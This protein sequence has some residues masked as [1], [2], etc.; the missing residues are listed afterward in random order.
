MRT[1]LITVAHGRHAHLRR[2]HLMVA[3]SEVAV[4]DYIVVAIDDAILVAMWEDH[5]G[6]TLLRQGPGRH[7]LP[8]AA[9]RNAGAAAALERGAE[10]LVF[11]DV[12]C[13]PDPGLVGH[14]ARAAVEHPESLLCGP[15]AYL[16]QTASGAVMTS[17][18]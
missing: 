6:V 4:D 3:R 9:A 16:P 14:Y 11:L 17:T 15:V 10:L 5:P 12:D 13:L 18:P 8:L 7:G 2:Q 1:A